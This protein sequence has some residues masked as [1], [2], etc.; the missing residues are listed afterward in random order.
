MARLMSF[1]TPIIKIMYN[2]HSTHF[3]KKYNTGDMIVNGK[4]LSTCDLHEYSL[5]V[6]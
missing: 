6:L 2:N 3:K 4:V 1:R 5:V